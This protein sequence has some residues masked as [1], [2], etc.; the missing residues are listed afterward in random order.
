MGRQQGRASPVAANLWR[1][2]NSL[3][4]SRLGVTFGIASN[5]TP[6]ALKQHRLAPHQPPWL[7]RAFVDLDPLN[8][9]RHIRGL[10][11]KNRYCRA[12]WCG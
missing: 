2:G 10:T 6:P 9:T 1:T 4:V 7:P 12:G 5:S 8:P 11:E 3:L